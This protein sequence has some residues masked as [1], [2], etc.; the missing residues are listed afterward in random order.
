MLFGLLSVRQMVETSGESGSL[1]TRR[2]VSHGRRRRGRLLDVDAATRRGS[3]CSLPRVTSPARRRG[4]RGAG[5]SFRESEMGVG[6]RDDDDDRPAEA[7]E[8]RGSPPPPPRHP[9]LRGFLAP[10]RAS[11]PRHRRRISR[12]DRPH[13]RR[14]RPGHR[15]LP[16][17]RASAAAIPSPRP[18][19]ST[20]RLHHHHHERL[21]RSV[22]SSNALVPSPPTRLSPSPPMRSSPS[23]P[24]RSSRVHRTRRR[25]TQSTALAA[26]PSPPAPLPHAPPAP[27]AGSSTGIS[28]PGV[29]EVVPLRGSTRRVAARRRWTSTVPRHGMDH[30][31]AS[32]GSAA[33]R[34]RR[35]R[36]NTRRAPERCNSWVFCPEPACWA[37]DIWNPP[38]AA[39]GSR[40]RRIPIG[41]R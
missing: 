25:S 1:S 17:R 20:R 38:S 24:T 8:T 13:R 15:T 23:P 6:P 19:S 21:K 12:R 39:V 34:A 31:V 30:R 36:G 22:E 29:G 3:T 28:V 10:P 40:C 5:R 11:R 9:R 2:V 33:R 16:R 14:R 35:T 41:R 32:A 4:G 7:A 27:S 18:P 26:L 37:P